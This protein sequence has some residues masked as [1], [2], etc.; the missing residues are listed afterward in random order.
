MGKGNRNNV[1]FQDAPRA[2]VYK[3]DD[4]MFYQN[5]KASMKYGSFPGGRKHF[6]FYL[7]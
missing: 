4:G 6:K 7:E 3:M 5:M 1:D 2:G